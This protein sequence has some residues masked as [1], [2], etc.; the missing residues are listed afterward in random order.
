MDYITYSAKLE[1]L[2]SLIEKKAAGTSK[3]L[4]AKL[5]VSERT[6]KRMIAC[7]RKQGIKINFNPKRKTYLYEGDLAVCQILTLFGC[8]I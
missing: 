3:M 2:K 5:R 7:L 4:A 6:V 1:Y 8:Y